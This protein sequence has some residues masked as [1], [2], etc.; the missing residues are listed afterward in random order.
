M[1][2]AGGGRATFLFNELIRISD[3]SKHTPI[4]WADNLEHV[5]CWA[6]REFFP[7][8]GGKSQQREIC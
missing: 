2:D 1:K 3:T 5:I 4:L 8:I 7:V 6:R